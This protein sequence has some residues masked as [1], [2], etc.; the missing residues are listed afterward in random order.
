MEGT[1]GEIVLFAGNFAPRNWAFCSG[2][3][4]Q[5]AQ[6]DALFSLIGTTYGGDGRTTFALP[7]LR[8]RV[9]LGA[10]TGP[11]LPTYQQGEAGGSER[12]SLTQAQ[13]PNH[14]HEVDTTGWQAHLGAFAGPAS[15]PTPGAAERLAAYPPMVL[16]YSDNDS[17]LTPLGAPG[18]TTTVHTA[19]SFQ[20]HENRQPLLGVNYVICLLGIYPSRS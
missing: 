11:G 15:L 5:I 8:G 6:N 17:G 19:G 3:L 1:I 14:S 18:L 20:A 10:G 12:V 9:P 7:D 16:P 13:I 4:L 2:Q